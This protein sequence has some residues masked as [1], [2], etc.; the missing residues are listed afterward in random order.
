M[1]GGGGSL[2]PMSPD[3]SSM[4]AAMAEAA[5]SGSGGSN[6]GSGGNPPPPPGRNIVTGYDVE[7]LVDAAMG[8]IPMPTGPTYLDAYGSP[9][10]RIVAIPL[11]PATN[12]SSLSRPMVD[13]DEIKRIVAEA[14]GVG[15]PNNNQS[16]L[17]PPPSQVSP[18]SASG[19]PNGNHNA[20]SRV[21]TL[22]NMVTDEDLATKEDH[23]SLMEEVGDECAKFGKLKQLEIPREQTLV[24]GGPVEPSA[25]RK[26]FLYYETADQAMDAA[27]ALQGRSFGTQ[28]VETA[29]YPESDFLAGKLR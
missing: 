4:A 17:P 22:L 5:A 28:T 6:V 21:L 20:P 9:L 25:V 11:V 19:S 27:R 8:Q 18:P 2:A 1:T 3:G 13:S 10:T 23:A 24:K 14:T 12:N 16:S 26:I 7:A 15:V 29:M